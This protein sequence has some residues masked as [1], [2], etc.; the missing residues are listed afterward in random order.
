MRQEQVQQWDGVARCC[1][2]GLRQRSWGWLGMP[3]HPVAWRAEGSEGDVEVAF[4]EGAHAAAGAYCLER[5]LIR[6]H[7]WSWGCKWVGVV[8]QVRWWSIR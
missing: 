3:Q 4:E 1:A 8:V 2:S 5:E 7:A 6:L